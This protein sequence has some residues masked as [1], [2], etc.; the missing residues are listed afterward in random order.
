MKYSL[1]ASMYSFTVCFEN[2]DNPEIS[3]ERSARLLEVAPSSEKQTLEELIMLLKLLKSSEEALEESELE[4]EEEESED[5]TD[6][7][8]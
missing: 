8:R 3:S 1:P 4:D 2:S 7:L 5:D 6:E